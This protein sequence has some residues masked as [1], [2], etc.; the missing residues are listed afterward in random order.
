MGGTWYAVEFKDS[1][2]KKWMTVLFTPGRMSMHDMESFYGASVERICICGNSRQAY[3]HL[4]RWRK[5]A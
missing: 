1:N 4:D 2:G 5:A 3:D